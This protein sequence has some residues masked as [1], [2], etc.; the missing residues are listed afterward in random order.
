MSSSPSATI[1]CSTCGKGIPAHTSFCIHCG[2]QVAHDKPPAEVAYCGSCGQAN[3]ADARFCVSCGAPLACGQGS[4]ATACPS[5]R[6]PRT[7]DATF[8]TSCGVRFGDAGTS[9]AVPPG[10]VTLCPFCKEEIRGG[11]IKC[12]HCNTV[13]SERVQTPQANFMSDPSIREELRK[14]K[15][16]ITLQCRECGYY[17]PMGIVK[18]VKPLWARWY[19][20]IPIC[21]T[22]IGLIA[23]LL[24]GVLSGLAGRFMLR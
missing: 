18:K 4:N 2:A 24:L 13:L 3:A 11:A 15:Q 9:A 22:G 8:C 21:L 1:V 19:I 6:E 14:Y 20:L 5:C 10:N 7:P 16:E 12:K 23:A 17:G